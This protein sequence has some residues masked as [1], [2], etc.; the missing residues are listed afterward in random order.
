MSQI[1]IHVSLST[2]EEQ[3]FQTPDLQQPFASLTSENFRETLA[4][5]NGTKAFFVKK[6][7][8]QMKEQMYRLL[9]NPIEQYLQQSQET[10]TAMYQEQLENALGNGAQLFIAEITSHVNNSLAAM[11]GEMDQ[12]VLLVKQEQLKKH[13]ERRGI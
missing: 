3:N 12:D 4:G 10:L 1:D 2:L 6:E 5:F 9:D 13:L 11:A 7:K 8:E